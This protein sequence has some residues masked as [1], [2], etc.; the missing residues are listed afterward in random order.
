MFDLLS[1]LPSL[2]S[3]L[4][5]PLSQLRR[6]VY[7]SARAVYLRSDDLLFFFLCVC[8][9]PHPTFDFAEHARQ[10]VVFF[11]AVSSSSSTKNTCRCTQKKRERKKR[12]PNDREKM[13]KKGAPRRQLLNS[14]FL[15]FYI[16]FPY[17]IS[18]YVLTFAV[19]CGLRE[20]T[21]VCRNPTPP[22]S[23]R[24][25]TEYLAHDTSP[26]RLNRTKF[27][28]HHLNPSSLSSITPHIWFERSKQ[29]KQTNP[30]KRLSFIPHN[31][32]QPLTQANEVST[33]PPTPHPPRISTDL[34]SIHSCISLPRPTLSLP[35]QN[36][37]LFVIRRS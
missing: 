5:I 11:A 9:F 25:R 27:P 22:S 28:F 8:L 24:L 18:H 20:A 15:F 19:F 37:S 31:F 35:S 7:V 6:A 33:T 1:L 34:T 4:L 16:I 13:T 17:S 26:P 32:S 12:V 36:P 23:T 29:T 21:G 2:F 14:L 30:T 3:P 10:G